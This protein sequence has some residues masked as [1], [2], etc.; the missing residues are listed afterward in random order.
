MR[1]GPAQFERRT[2]LGKRREIMVGRRDEAPLV[3]PYR[4]RRPNKAMALG[5]REVQMGRSIRDH[6]SVAQR[7]FR[8][9]HIP[10]TNAERHQRVVLCERGASDREVFDQSFVGERLAVA[11]DSAGDRDAARSDQRGEV[12]DVAHVP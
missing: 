8:S 10:H 1:A 11:S 7:A 4:L 2:T 3:P 6:P 5:R 12:S 9:S